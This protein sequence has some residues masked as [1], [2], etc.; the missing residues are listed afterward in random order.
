MREWVIIDGQQMPAEWIDRG[1]LL[2][3]NRDEWLGRYQDEVRIGVFHSVIYAVTTGIAI[4]VSFFTP[5]PFLI[6]IIFLFVLCGFY[7]FSAVRTSNEMR[8]GG[9]V[10]GI[11]ERGIEMPL[12]PYYY[13][14]L[15]IPWEEIKGVW[16]QPRIL[17]SSN[18]V[19]MIEV[20]NSRWR[21]R[22]SEYL[23]GPEGYAF[24]Q[25]KLAEIESGVV[26]PSPASSPPKLVLYSSG[27]PRVES[28]PGEEDL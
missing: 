26:P 7:L 22:T 15:F 5:F 28:V 14:R 3:R 11:Y 21:W 18:A 24:A 25:A 1:A 9:P 17:H 19:V 4:V 6:P 8:R 20:R 16:L 10:P 12:F 13:Q 2:I 23:L 27:G